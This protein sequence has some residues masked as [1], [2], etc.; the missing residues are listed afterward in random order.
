MAARTLDHYFLEPKDATQRRYE[1]LRAVFV[2][3]LS[4]KD[5]A[6]RFHVSYGTAR[7]WASEFRQAF[8]SGQR[9]PFSR[10]HRAPQTER[11]IPTNRA[12]KSPT[13]GCCRCQPDAD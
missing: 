12:S 1:T 2:E 7:N 10:A 13:P 9:P 6:Q 4:L 11:R 8:Q 3:G 5:A